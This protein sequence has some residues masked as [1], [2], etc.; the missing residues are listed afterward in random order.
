LT[1]NYVEAKREDKLNDADVISR[2]EEYN[3]AVLQ[4]NGAGK[5]NG[6]K[7]WKYLFIPS[8]QITP[9]STFKPLCKRFLEVSE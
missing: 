8:M 2:K 9:V 4:A 1:I 5:A 7:E 3:I 6:Y